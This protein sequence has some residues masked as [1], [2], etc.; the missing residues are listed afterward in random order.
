MSKLEKLA[1]RIGEISDE[2][3]ELKSQREINLEKCHGS[4]DEEF[5]VNTPS[6][7]NGS[8]PF[9]NCLYNAYAWV[10][11]DREDGLSTMFHD[12]IIDY[13]CENCKGA[14]LAKAKIGLLKQERGP[15]VGNISR[16]GK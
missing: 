9:N 3:I 5:D 11:S 15:L 12:V 6:A 16:I 13:G 10:K 14:Y 7:Y 2:I 4:E 8:E 1:I